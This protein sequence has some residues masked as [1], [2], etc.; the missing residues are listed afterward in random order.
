[1]NQ[2]PLS[3][4]GTIISLFFCGV[5]QGAKEESTSFLNVALGVSDR[6]QNNSTALEAWH[7]SWN[8][9]EPQPKRDPTVRLTR[10]IKDHD[11]GR[12]ENVV[13]GFLTDGSTV[14]DTLPYLQ[15]PQRVVFLAAHASAFFQRGNYRSSAR[16]CALLAG[17]LPRMGQSLMVRRLGSL[18]AFAMLKTAT[19]WGREV[20][21][22][23]LFSGILLS[24]NVDRMEWKNTLVPALRGALSAIDRSGLPS[25]E[26]NSAESETPSVAL[27]LEAVTAAT[28]NNPSRALELLKA[29]ESRVQKKVAAQQKA[30]RFE[31][32]LGDWLSG[33]ISADLGRNGEAVVF[34]ERAVEEMLAIV[35]LEA[36][37]VKPRR[38]LSGLFARLITDAATAMEKAGEPLRALVMVSQL[39]QVLEMMPH[40]AD[41][42]WLSHIRMELALEKMRLS[43]TQGQLKSQQSLEGFF[44][45]AKE[46]FDRF[47]RDERRLV[48]LAQSVVTG[49]ALLGFSE[50][51]TL[52][53]SYGLQDSRFLTASRAFDLMSDLQAELSLLQM[54]DRSAMLQALSVKPEQ[55]EAVQQFEVGFLLLVRQLQAAADLV[56]HLH[57]IGH[58]NGQKRQ[59]YVEFLEKAEGELIE[60]RNRAYL[61]ERLRFPFLE[62]MVPWRDPLQNAEALRSSNAASQDVTSLDGANVML[63][64][65]TEVFQRSGEAVDNQVGQVEMQRT[66]AVLS[67]STQGVLSLLGSV[68]SRLEEDDG[69]VLT[70]GSSE[71]R[72]VLVKSMTSGLNHLRELQR[73]FRL[74][75]EERSLWR[76]GWKERMQGLEVQLEKVRVQLV[77]LVRA[78]ERGL[79]PLVEQQLQLRRERVQGSL[80]QAFLEGRLTYSQLAEQ[81]GNTADSLGALQKRLE[82]AGERGELW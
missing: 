14:S 23:R 63:D 54:S 76:E 78:D 75:A 55:H 72:R 70:P 46:L 29:H 5:A 16:F 48:E 52:A 45:S 50:L 1:M 65:L 2:F 15:G 28:R 40:S 82:Q 8:E 22:S 47:D 31:L 18:C 53:E 68:V 74:E 27:L 61:G 56:K 59:R 57:D 13:G 41:F 58:E 39:K 10:V 34:F 36:Q 73:K 51:R 79:V 38:L 19:I 6:I 7:A 43:A 20:R 21:P 69:I 80:L 3:F 42:S 66:L 30:S 12:F 33:R 44:S 4:F 71:A 60:G 62:R 77:D 35:E 49:D 24:S 25:L 81:L 67:H 26:S 17:E 64:R 32:A 11:A 37:E 9:A